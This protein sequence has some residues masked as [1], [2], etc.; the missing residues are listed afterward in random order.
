MIVNL[1]VSYLELKIHLSYIQCM[2]QIL[3]FIQ[4]IKHDIDDYA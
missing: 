2:M 3:N 1:N 4:N